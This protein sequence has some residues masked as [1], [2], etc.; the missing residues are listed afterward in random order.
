MKIRERLLL[1]GEQAKDLRVRTVL[2]WIYKVS[3]RFSIIFRNVHE[4][5]QPK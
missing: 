1:C 3:S 5:S 4:E 2:S